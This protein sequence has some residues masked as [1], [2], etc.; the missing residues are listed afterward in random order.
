MKVFLGIMAVFFFLA[1][2]EERDQK[3]KWTYAL[4][5]IADIAA[6]TA[7]TIFFR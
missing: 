7:L 4:T 1:M 6:M 3:K 5:L 2:Y